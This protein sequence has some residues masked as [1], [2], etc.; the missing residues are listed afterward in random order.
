MSPGRPLR[1]ALLGAGVGFAFVLAVAVA[2]DRTGTGDPA[3]CPPVAVHPEWSVARRWNETLLDAIRR[4]HP[5][6]TVHSRNLF[7]VSAAMWDAWA[8][9]EASAAGYFV[10]EKHSAPDVAAA[11]NEA[12]SYAAY[13]ILEHRYIEASGASDS[14]PEFDA[15]MTALCYPVAVTTS[16]GNDPASLGN[17]IAATI[18]EIGHSDGSNELGGY[19]ADYEAVNEPLTVKEPGT[20]TADPNRWQPLEIEG[21]VVNR[22]TDSLGES[23]ALLEYLTNVPSQGRIARSGL[24]RIPINEAVSIDPT[25]S[26]LEAALVRQQQRSVLLPRPFEENLA[27]LRALGDEVYLQVARGLLEPPVA[28]EVLR[29]R[30]VEILEAS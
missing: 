25:I 2:V 6:P 22:H 15:L 17:R 9:Y 14:I 5:A 8:A 28:A 16:E 20:T 30:Y 24:G 11:R 1:L 7:H 10:D 13:R 26:P 19:E 18:I 27:E 3:E 29:E 23:L 4:D 12:I 21:M